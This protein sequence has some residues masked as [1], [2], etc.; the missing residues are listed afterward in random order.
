MKMTLPL[1]APTLSRFIMDS[2]ETHIIVFGLF[3]LRS[4]LIHSRTQ[5]SAFKSSQAFSLFNITVVCP[6]VSAILAPMKPSL[7]VP[8]AKLTDIN[9]MGR[10]HNPIF[11]IFPL[12]HGFALCF[13]THSML[14]KC[15]TDQNTNTILLKS[16]TF[17]IPPIIAHCSRLLSLLVMNNFQCGSFLIPEMLHSVC[18]LMALALSSDATRLL[19][20]LF[21]STIIFLLQ[22]D[23]AKK[24]SLPLEPY[25]DP[26]NLPTLI[27]SCGPLSRSYYN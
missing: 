6:L 1:Y 9:L 2:P 18:P 7:P 20:P 15:N 8:I 14:L 21:Y 25:L 16:R 17:S 26:K 12:F 27:L 4:P 19:G 22:K 11:S 5:R 13:P 10:L 24:I 23:F 3:F